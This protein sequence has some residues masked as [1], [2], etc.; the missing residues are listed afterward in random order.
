M[1]IGKYVRLFAYGFAVA[2]IMA[3]PV[4]AAEEGK[5]DTVLTADTD[6]DEKTGEE[7]AEETDEDMTLQSA[8]DGETDAEELENEDYRYKV[9]EDGSIT[10][11]KYIGED[12]VIVTPEEIDG[13]PVTVI[14]EYC[15]YKKI[16][17]SG[18][19]VS[20][21][22]VKIGDKAFAEDGSYDDYTG[23]GNLKV[24]LPKSL[25]AIGNEVFQ[26]TYIT[27]IYFYDGLESMGDYVCSFDSRLSQ[28]RIPDSVKSIGRMP[29]LGAIA[30][31]SGK[32]R[33]LQIYGGEVAKQ[34]AEDYQYGQ[35]AGDDMN[36]ISIDN[37]IE[38]AQSANGEEDDPA[39]RVRQI[40]FDNMD[41]GYKNITFPTPE[42][43]KEENQFL[44]VFGAAVIILFPV[45]LMFIYGKQSK[46]QG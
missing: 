39:T 23:P 14:G 1:R 13:K 46:K 19:K 3:G 7:P 40:Y 4:S 10:L 32:A 33:T 25:K 43:Q 17:L 37:L 45:L 5:A 30:D 34:V 27:N 31:G 2:S 20:E 36:E 12:A 28:I 26:N 16:Q 22:V 38:K 15:F 21:G 18:I 29:F 24:V 6:I 41:T 9:N 8:A 44:I 11:V 42:M 35:Y